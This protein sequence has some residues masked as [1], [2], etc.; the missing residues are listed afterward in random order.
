MIFQLKITVT[1]TRKT[2]MKCTL[3]LN[4]H[5][6]H[7]ELHLEMHLE[8][9]YS[10]SYYVRRKLTLNFFSQFSFSVVNSAHLHFWYFSH[11]LEGPLACPRQTSQ[12]KIHEGILGT[13]HWG[14]H[15]RTA[16]THS[17]CR[18]HGHS[19]FTHIA[20]HLRLRTCCKECYGLWNLE[21]Q[22]CPEIH[23]V[24]PTLPHLMHISR[25]QNWSQLFLS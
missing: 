10:L 6:M 18:Q 4:H 3:K 20:T 12:V 25:E 22:E 14:L 15:E 16:A 1:S 9:V 7:F 17:R 8:I 24:A 5:E 11:P 13:L 21:Y 2:I 23:P 19:K